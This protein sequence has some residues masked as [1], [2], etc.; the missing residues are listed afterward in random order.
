[1]LVLVSNPISTRLSYE[2]PSTIPMFLSFSPS[3]DRHIFLAHTGADAPSFVALMYRGHVYPTSVCGSS[4]R[5]FLHRVII[6]TSAYASPCLSCANSV[7]QVSFRRLI[8]SSL[9]PTHSL[10]TIPSVF[11]HPLATKLF[12]W[13]LSGVNAASFVK[14]CFILPYI[15]FLC[16]VAKILL[17]TSVRASLFVENNCQDGVQPSLIIRIISIC[18][19]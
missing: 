4:F 19:F 6:G 3:D 2:L 8:P 12:R 7:N 13:A 1:M 15:C 17:F 11:L 16:D 18:L 9:S 10:Y 5:D 14:L